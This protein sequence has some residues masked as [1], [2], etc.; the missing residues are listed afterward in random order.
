[1]NF[2]IL[3]IQK[4]NI[5]ILNKIMVIMESFPKLI[6]T[7]SFDESVLKFE[8]KL[9]SSYTFG[10]H[11]V[12]SLAGEYSIETQKVSVVINLIKLN[13][14]NEL[15]ARQSLAKIE[16]TEPIDPIVALL[17]YSKGVTVR[18][19]FIEEIHCKEFLNKY[20]QIESIQITYTEVGTPHYIGIPPKQT[21][22]QYNEYIK[23]WCKNYI[24]TKITNLQIDKMPFLTIYNMKET[25]NGNKGFKY[26]TPSDLTN[27]IT[28][29]VVN[30]T[31]D[32]PDLSKTYYSLNTITKGTTDEILFEDGLTMVIITADHKIWILSKIQSHNR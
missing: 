23:N 15:L 21:F 10:T 3:C 17:G 20:Q 22:T 11:V 8:I 19:T 16:Y 18:D 28:I 5:L 27:A 31:T 9:P 13:K 32:I 14:N 24:Q 25:Y 4:L 30:T 29:P 1:M 7:P 6:V 12:S 2:T 26:N